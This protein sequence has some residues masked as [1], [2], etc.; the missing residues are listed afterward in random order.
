M[1]I[2][3]KNI[4][5]NLRV[6]LFFAEIDNSQANSGQ[7]PQQVLI[8]GQ[9]TAGGTDVANNPA[10]CAGVG[11]AQSRYGANSMLARMVADYRGADSFGTLWCVGLADAGGAAAA[12]DTVTVGGAP[13]ASGTVS[14]Y[15]AGTRYAVA[16]TSSMTSAQI[17]TAIGAAINADPTCLVTAAVAGSVV[18]LTAVNKGLAG[19]DID[20]RLNYYGATQ[21]ETLPVGLTVAIATAQ[22]AGGTTNPTLTSALANLSDVQFD[23]IVLPYTDTA[24]L[25][26]LQAFLSDA[27]GRWSWSE[28]LY[29]HVYTAFRG[30]FSACTTFGLTRNN[31]HETALGFYDS[32]TPAW[33]AA[34][35]LCGSS[36]GSLRAD[37]GQPLQ[38]LP[39]VGMLPPPVPSRFI[40]TERNTLLFD[41]IST[42]TVDAGGT[43]YIENLITTY[44][45]NSLGQA[46]DSYLEIETM[47]T[48][49]YI[50]EH[51][52][53]AINTKYSRMKLADDGTTLSAGSN[54]VTPSTIK[55]EII[56]QYQV[57]EDGGYVQDSDSFAQNVQV[58]RNATNPN[59]VDV[60]F[61]STLIDQLRV[62]A[63]LA[64]FRL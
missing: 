59:R 11:D 6:P 20:V 64:Q 48:L 34:A 4:P 5:Q 15:V 24:S 43:C 23:A 27:A 17:A 63:L 26:A 8:L 13:T 1:T 45:T 52:A 21:G 42:F 3:F 57:L 36:I 32:P 58:Q 10:V 61:P 12:T 40:M 16:V 31:Q 18:T 41:G 14:L 35:Q 51:L 46:D 19:N 9:M 49:A 44:Q 60:L 47:Y 38:T 29:G 25:N 62:F 33:S 50:L 7:I 30:T 54:V 56:A 37:P 22:C 2:S 55:A 39:I 28:Q 53:A